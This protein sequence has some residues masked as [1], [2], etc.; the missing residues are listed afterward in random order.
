MNRM[1]CHQADAFPLLCVAILALLK[2][3]KNKKSLLRLALLAGAATAA[4]AYDYPF[5]WM[6]AQALLGL[7]LIHAAIEKGRPN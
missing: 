1:I 3:Y 2:I 4:L 6:Y 7:L 5:Y